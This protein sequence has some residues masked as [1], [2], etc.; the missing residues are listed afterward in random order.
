MQLATVT[1]SSV[2]LSK[3]QGKTDLGLAS[4]QSTGALHPMSD[5]ELLQHLHN[6][7]RKKNYLL[8]KHRRDTM[9]CRRMY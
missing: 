6:I 5:V 1:C 2:S 4:I 8:S 7:T 3:P 9:T